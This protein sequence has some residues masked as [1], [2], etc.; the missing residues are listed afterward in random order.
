MAIPDYSNIKFDISSMNSY[1]KDQGVNVAA[2]DTAK[3]NTIFKECD[4]EGAKNEKGENIGDGVLRGQERAT[5]LNKIKSACPQIYDKVVDFFTAV[6]TTEDIAATKEETYQRLK[7]EQKANDK[8]Q[9]ESNIKFGLDNTGNYDTKVVNQWQNEVA[10]E[11]QK[12]NAE[13]MK[14]IERQELIFNFKTEWIRK[15]DNKTLTTQLKEL[16]NIQDKETFDKTLTEFNTKNRK[17]AAANN[18]KF[19]LGD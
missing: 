11:L 8:A 12:T 15:I 7:N 4:T 10:K 9:A 16:D 1:F 19:G 5:F 3:L 2:G 14:E 17:L 18:I 13:M 6:E